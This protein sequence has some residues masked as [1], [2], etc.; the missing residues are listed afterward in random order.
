MNYL[1]PAPISEGEVIEPEFQPP[2]GPSLE[3]LDIQ[4]IV[5]AFR[6]RLRLFLGLTAG[7]FLLA[8]AYVL[9]AT[10]IYT[11]TSRVMLI[12]RQ[13]QPAPQDTKD[14]LG[15][16]PNGGDQVDSELQLVQS[17]HIVETVVDQLHLERDEEF[18]GT[19][20]TGIGAVKKE[21]RILLAG[22]KLKPQT[23]DAIRSVTVTQ[24]LNA[25]T[26]KRV[27]TS[28][29]IDIAFAS[30][31]RDKAATVSN[32][33][34]SA[35]TNDQLRQKFAANSDAS[36]VLSGKVRQ[37]RDQAEA[38]LARLQDYRIKHNLLATN[39][40]STD[41][42]SSVTTQE[43]STYNQQVAEARAQLAM[44]QAAL[45]T[46]REQLRRGSTGDDLGEVL[47]SSLITSLRAQ[48]AQLSAKVA[49]LLSRL[50]PRH[51]DLIQAQHQLADLNGQIQTEIDRIVSNL[52]AKVN[53]S[54]NRLA[55]LEGTLG[56]AKA[57]LAQNNAAMATLAALQQAADV[58]RENY[59]DYLRRYNQ[60]SS[61]SGLQMPDARIISRADALSVKIDPNLLLFAAVGLAV[62]LTF[63]A[64]AVLLANALDSTILTTEDVEK[65]LGADCLA[66]IPL[67]ASVPAI[68]RTRPV[69]AVV[70]HPWSV[71]AEAFRNLRASLK[72]RRP[73]LQVIM[74]TSALPQEGKTTVSACLARSIALDGTRVLLVDCDLRQCGASLAL[75]A[76]ASRPG[77]A[78]LL[79]GA[80]TLDEVLVEDTQTGA[81]ILPASVQRVSSEQ[82]FGSAQFDSL[83]ADLRSRFELIIL[84]TPPVLAVSD[85]RLIAPRADAVIVLARWR[86]TTE[87]ALRSA[88][89]L[90]PLTAA[91]ASGVAISCVDLRQQSR[92]GYGDPGYYYKE[93]QDYYAPAGNNPWLETRLGKFGLIAER[94]KSWRRK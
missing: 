71:F 28:N 66:S 88:M 30:K 27:A 73:D 51:P 43:I 22:G 21:I 74:T 31:D 58:S 42:G 87:H 79:L 85:A 26:V 44:D 84:D 76:P 54:A 12:T 11:A 32:A 14:V 10:P 9:I 59:E 1:R 41:S 61:Q 40:S 62:G 57:S 75:Q 15:Q 77:L 91:Q 38:D 67:A 46:A 39:G 90:L 80:A 35:Y 92:Y 17:R 64:G 13:M 78:D 3:R 60:I 86:R 29:A 81:V 33:F 18:N 16:L 70:H 63:G 4:P 45:A 47:G 89:R 83:L 94:L 56:S 6:R 55:S 24:V 34:A 82:A 23:A 2:S 72:H 19:N 7:G 5:A 52:Q 65:R 68:A 53:I 49:D 20:P 25:L 8:I 50:G 93:I 37:L 69:D 48:Q 36:S